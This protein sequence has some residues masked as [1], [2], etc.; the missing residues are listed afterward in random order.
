MRTAKSFCS[1]PSFPSL[2]SLPCSAGRSARAGHLAHAVAVQPVARATA[3]LSGGIYTLA[4]S[5]LFASGAARADEGLSSRSTDW[6]WPQLQARITLQTA[7]LTPVTLARGA[8]PGAAAQRGQILGAAMLGDYVFARPSMGQFRT[9][10]GVV[11]GSNAGAPLFAASAAARLDVQVR[12]VGKLWSNAANEPQATMAYVGLGYSS[13]RLWGNLSVSADFGL[14]AARPSGVAGVG[15]ALFGAQ[16]LDAALR[17][18]R[19]APLMQLG[20]RYS[21]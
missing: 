15:R 19:W 8:E 1:R 5:L 16:A 11:L 7:S 2:P 6:L 20:V 9:T 17:D 18:M 12:D 21:Y 3:R 14:A 13:P 10:S 4:L